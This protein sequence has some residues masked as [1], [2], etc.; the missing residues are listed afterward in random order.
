MIIAHSGMAGRL[1]WC[2]GEEITISYIEEE[3]LEVEERRAALAG[4][5]FTCG[6]ER[7]SAEALAREVAAV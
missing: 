7:C 3:E 4:Y 1:L 2:A 5:G 6:C